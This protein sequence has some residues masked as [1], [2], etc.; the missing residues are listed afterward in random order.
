MFSSS[1]AILQGIPKFEEELVGAGQ[2][3]EDERHPLYWGIRLLLS[4]HQ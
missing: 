4:G 1:V 2:P 3:R